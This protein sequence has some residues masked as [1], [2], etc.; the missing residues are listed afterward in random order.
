MLLAHVLLPSVVL[1]Y[2]YKW[3]EEVKTVRPIDDAVN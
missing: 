3:Y 1:V 2:V